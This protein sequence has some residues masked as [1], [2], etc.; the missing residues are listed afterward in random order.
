MRIAE[1]MIVYSDAGHDRD[2]FCVV[3]KLEGSYAYIADGRHRT[4]ANPKRKNL[5]HLKATNRIVDLSQCDT[6]K[7]IRNACWP[8]QYGG[9]PTAE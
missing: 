2:R 7:K 3:I 8:Y 1:G 4:L 9:Q 6:D 5:R